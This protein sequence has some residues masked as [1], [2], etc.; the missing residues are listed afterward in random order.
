MNQLKNC[1][2]ENYKRFIIKDSEGRYVGENSIDVKSGVY[3]FSP[4][5]TNGYQTY[6]IREDAEKELNILTE[7]A[8]KAYLDIK[9]FVFEVNI[10]DI[11]IVE[12][13]LEQKTSLHIS[14]IPFECLNINQMKSL[15]KT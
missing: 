4:F 1:K 9:F 14:P 10:Y 8:R 2:K 12:A 5:L 7:L 3:T 6:K 15:V 13:I 11:A